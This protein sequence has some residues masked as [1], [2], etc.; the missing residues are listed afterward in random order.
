MTTTPSSANSSSCLGC[1][2][3]ADAKY[4]KTSS[5]SSHTMTTK[6][7]RCCDS[8]IVFKP[9]GLKRQFCSPECKQISDNQ[10]RTQKSRLI[11]NHTC[12]TCGKTMIELKGRRKHCS[13]TCKNIHKTDIRWVHNL[14]DLYGLTLLEYETKFINQNGRCAICRKQETIKRNGRKRRLSVDHCHETNKVRGLLCSRCNFVIGHVT[15]DWLILD[16]AIEYLTYWHSKH[17][18]SKVQATQESPILN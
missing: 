17:R 13:D 12:Q 7:C 3:Y 9:N 4:R 1:T 5:T 6:R 8:L 11:K 10:K 14:S 2:S 15:D 18:S 16:N